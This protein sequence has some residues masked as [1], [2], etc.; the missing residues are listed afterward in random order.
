[1]NI[2]R[3][4]SV[5]AMMVI[6]T[7][8]I[9]AQT[10]RYRGMRSVRQLILNLE[11]HTDQF[12]NSLDAQLDSMTVDTTTDDINLFVSDFDSS[13]RQLLDR[14]DQRQAT[15]ADVQEVL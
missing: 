14:F 12:R 13:V 6:A 7:C 10:P 8:P 1:M 2:R 15:S 5:V 9:Y 3:S 11:N 4:L